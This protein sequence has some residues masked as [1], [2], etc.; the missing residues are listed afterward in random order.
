MPDRAAC[1]SLG[2]KPH[3]IA[4]VFMD[5]SGQAMAEGTGAM[6]RRRVVRATLPFALMSLAGTMLSG[7]EGCV[8]ELNSG[9]CV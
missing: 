6:V 2:A 7:D 1:W 3:T 5:H 9:A 4:T 8:I